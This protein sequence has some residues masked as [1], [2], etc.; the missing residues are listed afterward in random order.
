MAFCLLSLSSRSTDSD[1]RRQGGRARQ[2][3]VLL[4]VAA[5]V[6]VLLSSIPRGSAQRPTGDFAPDFERMS[7]QQAE[8]DRAWRRA[9]DGF[10]RMEKISYRSRAGD[11]DVPAFVFQPL[12]PLGSK[13]HPALVWVHEGIRGHVAELYVPYVR[14]AVAQGYVVI[15]P[16]YRG[17]IGYGKS[18]YD[19][20]DYGGREVD[21]VVTAASVIV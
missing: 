9:S 15:A 12:R 20:I 2:S 1:S 19:S 6:L 7:R 4:W 11:M 21:D 14:E 13:R 3:V 17:G 10:M 5:L 16:E 8:T 18:F